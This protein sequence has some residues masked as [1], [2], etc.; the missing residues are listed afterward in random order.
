MRIQELRWGKSWK[1]REQTLNEML[2]FSPFL[3]P[4]R[5]FPG[6]DFSYQQTQCVYLWLLAPSPN[7]GST[8]QAPVLWSLHCHCSVWGESS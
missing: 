2:G 4:R 8:I 1:A 7:I 3:C 6:G 5:S